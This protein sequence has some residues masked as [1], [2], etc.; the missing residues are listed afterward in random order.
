[1]IYTGYF[2]QLPIYKSKNLFPISISRT[3]P[4][5]Y[6]GFSELLAAP[7]I[8]LSNE[9]KVLNNEDYTNKY[10]IE[11]DK[12]KDKL[13]LWIENLT[14]MVG[15]KDIILLCHARSEDFCYRHILADYL[16]KTF[17]MNIKEFINI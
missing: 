6:E 12:I 17:N 5:W 10:M 11:L 2:E 8:N 16:N 4:D 1:M 9:F 3:S 13:G 14:R 7:T 15:N